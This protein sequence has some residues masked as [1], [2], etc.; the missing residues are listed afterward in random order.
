MHH[1]RGFDTVCIDLNVRESGTHHQSSRVGGLKKGC[2]IKDG[3]LKI[4]QN[5]YHVFLVIG[6]LK[7]LR[8]QRYHLKIPLTITFGYHELTRF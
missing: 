2:I 3:Y 5:T 8:Y 6:I 1:F 4:T 7:L